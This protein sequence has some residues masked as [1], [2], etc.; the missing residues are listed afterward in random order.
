MTSVFISCLFILIIIIM[1]NSKSQHSQKN[2]QGTSYYSDYECAQKA[3]NH[4]K[5]VSELAKEIYDNM[6]DYNADGVTSEALSDFMFYKLIENAEN[7]SLN[8]D[9]CP[10]CNNYRAK[11]H[12][13]ESSFKDDDG[14]SVIQVEAGDIM[15]CT[16]CKQYFGLKL[17]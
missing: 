16:V 3:V 6:P 15:I 10:Q 11:L 8:Y 12:I 2:I 9:S 4:N 7:V 14:H 17:R 5:A 13:S 1:L